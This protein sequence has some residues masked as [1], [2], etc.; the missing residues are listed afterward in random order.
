[1]CGCLSHAPKWGPGLQPRHVPWLGLKPGTFWFTGWCSI[2]WAIAARTTIIF[3]FVPPSS[4]KPAQGNHIWGLRQ[5][6]YFYSEPGREES[7]WL[8]A[9]TVHVCQCLKKSGIILFL[10]PQETDGLGSVVSHSTKRCWLCLRLGVYQ[11][12][13]RGCVHYLTV[14]L[15]TPI[16]PSKIYFLLEFNFEVFNISVMP[17]VAHDS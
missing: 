8:S 12:F 6:I 2:H 9:I 14:S 10:W 11:W 1:M 5:S 4:W 13:V 7:G 15:Q 16:M 3:L 17:S